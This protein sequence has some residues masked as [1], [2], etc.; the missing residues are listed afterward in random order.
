MFKKIV[1]ISVLAFPLYA[2][3]GAGGNNQVPEID[4][5]TLPLALGLLAGAIAL[6]R[7]KK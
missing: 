2:F 1:L 6:I 5:A 3:A 4:G 7:R